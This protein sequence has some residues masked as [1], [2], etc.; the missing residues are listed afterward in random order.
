MFGI[1]FGE[2]ILLSVIVLILIGP[3]QLPEVMKSVAKVVK[4]L[5]QAKTEIHRSI[6]QDETIRSVKDTVTD[7]RSNVDRSVKKITQDLI[8]S[9]HDDKK[10]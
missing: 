6:N 3:K 8:D 7:M 5:T 2:L 9:S 10:L 4:D 1:G